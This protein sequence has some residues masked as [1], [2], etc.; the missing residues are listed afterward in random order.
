M[1]KTDCEN[2]ITIPQIIDELKKYGVSAERRS[3]YEDIEALKS[4]GLDILVYKNKHYNYYIASRDFQLPELKLLAD[5]V[6]SAKFLTAK[7]S[8]QLLKKI[9][10]LASIHEGKQL[11]R[12]VYM[13]N[14]VKS[15]NEY[16]YLNLDKIHEAIQNKKQISFSYFDYGL[17][18]KRNYREGKRVASPLSLVWDNERYYLVAYYEKHSENLTNFRI[19]KM[20]NIEILQEE[21]NLNMEGF[22]LS[23]YINSS[24]GM[25]SC[26]T[27]C[28]KLRFENSLLNVVIDKFGLNSKIIK[29]DDNH[30]FAYLKVKVGEP[31]FGWI[32][33]FGNKVNICEPEELKKEYKNRLQNIINEI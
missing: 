30:F 2:F 17:D 19:D 12:Q 11:K 20:E 31:F 29:D 15:S 28:V 18:K 8:C 3:L 5:A 26:K 25:F 27:K 32:F 6:C 10:S 9:E 23:E 33:Q 7:K 4:F 13:L 14:R 21:V 1:E 22:S 24:F 16:I